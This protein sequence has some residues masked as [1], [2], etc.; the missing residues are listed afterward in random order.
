MRRTLLSLV[1]GSIAAASAAPAQQAQAP[2]APAAAAAQE[3]VVERGAAPG[4]AASAPAS[5][6]LAS[7]DANALMAEGERLARKGDLGGAQAA[8]SR[9]AT[10]AEKSGDAQLAAAAAESALAVAGQ[11]GDRGPEVARVAAIG[12]AQAALVAD[13]GA[14]AALGAGPSSNA[15]PPGAAPSSATLASLGPRPD[16]GGNGPPSMAPPPESLSPRYESKRDRRER[17][18]HAHRLTLTGWSL[19]PTEAAATRT[20][21]QDS[22]HG[23][24]IGFE[25][26]MEF[27]DGWCWTGNYRLGLGA[28]TGSGP[29]F[30][31]W[32][33]GGFG[34]DAKFLRLEVLI[35]LG[36]DAIG[37]STPA[38][39]EYQLVPAA[40]IGYDLRGKIRFG[41]AFNLVGSYFAANRSAGDVGERR[42]SA[43]IEIRGVSLGVQKISLNHGPDTAKGKGAADVL[44]GQVAIGF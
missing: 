13:P 44:L 31:G 24:M 27:D 21:S 5:G 11:R 6:P 15:A 7:D 16:D 4:A 41:R 40:I 1:I 10:V 12:R 8:W 29:S 2:A 22:R 34:Y 43:A 28:Q 35:G 25:R 18:L 32:L 14:L 42:L 20:L 33:A 39:T 3:Q 17:G 19:D 9:A 36:A 30:D 37:T 26:R 23:G 38:A